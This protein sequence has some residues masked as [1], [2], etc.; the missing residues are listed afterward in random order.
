VDPVQRDRIRDDLRGIIRG[1]LL[2][3][4]LSRVLY[5]TDASIFQVQ[6]LGVV[7]P[8]DEA[9]VSE[10][11]RYASANSVPLIPRGAGSGLAGESLGEGL[12]VDLS[13]HLRVISELRS[14]Q[15]TV[16]PGVVLQGLNELLAEEGRRF[17]PDPGSAEQCTLGGML[18]TNASG[19]RILQH[20]YTRD[21]VISLRVV[22]DSGEVVDAGRQPR[23]PEAVTPSGRLQDIVSS[24]STLLDGKDDLIRRCQPRTPFNRCGYLLDNVLA[25]DV[26]DLPK[27]LVGS[28]GTLGLF[29][30][31]TLRTVPLPGG[32]SLVLLAFDSLEAA[33]RAAQKALPTG[34]AACDL[35]DRRL[36]T[37]ARGGD[38]ETAAL[39][40]AAAE[41]ILLVEYESESP[42]RARQSAVDLAEQLHHAE[43]LGVYA[44][45]AWEDADIERLWRV[46]ESALPSLYGLRGG[47]QPI[48]FIED[49]G[50]P[51]DRLSECLHGIQQI[52]RRQGTTSSFLV[53]AATGQ[54]HARPFLDL[55][56]PRDVAKLGPLSEEIHGLVLDLGGTVS[57]Q[58]GT[59][60]ART[61]W[62]SRQYGPLFP[63]FRELKSI[64]DPRQIFNPGKIVG[65]G[66]QSNAWPLRW[67]GP[68]ATSSASVLDATVRT[69]STQDGPAIAP[70]TPTPTALQLV[71][72]DGEMSAESDNCNGCGTCRT[73]VAAK[74]MCPIFRAEHTE[75]ATPRA[76][77][78]LMRHLLLETHL[79]L[80][81]SDEVRAV[82]DLCVNC[83]MCA[84]ECPAHVNVPKLMLEAKAANVAQHGLDRASW[85]LSRT[86]S[87]AWLGSALAPFTNAVMGSRSLRWLLEK[88]F[89]VSRHRR[90]PA[91]AYRSF[92]RRARR[93]G[94][95]RRPRSDRPRVAY[96]VDIFANYND[97]TIAEAVVAVL[98]HNDIEVYVPQGQLG[99]GMA[100]LAYGDVEQARESLEH[101][102]RLFAEFA[103]EGHSILCSEPTAA[104]LFRQDALHLLDDPDA[105]LVAEHVVEA[106]AYLADQHRAGR[107]RTDFQ[108]L[109]FTVGHHV[110]CHLKALGRSPAGPNLLALIPGLRVRTIDVSCSG[111]AGT[112]G[113]TAE[114]YATSL[115]AGQPMLAEMRRTDVQF[116]S[117]EC[118]TCRLQMEDGA[119]KRTLHPLQYLALA[120][121]LMPELA[122]RLRKPIRELVL[123]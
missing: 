93:R 102:L 16:E 3:D 23:W 63:L 53:H 85:V 56:D 83:K 2:F 1:E 29:T 60:L 105:R 57:S 98:H 69:A 50:V 4:D 25:A 7:A 41:A 42:S 39:V 115:A 81:P 12:V 46:R 121:G 112:F 17:A 33:L 122:Q 67:Q 9:D 32:R 101:N 80:L 40:P 73:E 97:P 48:A 38:A 44:L 123:R 119:R 79:P 117:T 62:V 111:M 71:W 14:D 26:L 88:L 51:P 30:E 6:P 108:R 86:E 120:Y 45:V 43:G 100:P 36:L 95:T 15:V 49:V 72:R 84:T 27:L 90:L 8:R 89:G 106:T 21:H 82:A 104:L 110:P 116:G 87:F 13:R 109:D 31:A 64:F 11:V 107:L 58:H 91:F 94:W 65:P 20:G 19:S 55:R 75:A 22:L 77:A 92:L 118:S 61:A 37:L 103:R 74:R 68:A 59:G 66:L 96:F 70:V 34:M 76:K 35:M 54:I 10:L 113:L 78:N 47:A 99:C 5:S 52:L 24:V 114:N 28:E 18:G